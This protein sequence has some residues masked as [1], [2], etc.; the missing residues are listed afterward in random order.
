M[1][2][3][4]ATAPQDTLRLLGIGGADRGDASGLSIA[5]ASEPDDGEFIF[6]VSNEE[7]ETPGRDPNEASYAQIVYW[8]IPRITSCTG[9]SKDLE[10]CGQVGQG[11]AW[12]YLLDLSLHSQPLFGRRGA[13]EIKPYAFA[14]ATPDSQP[15]DS[16]VGIVWYDQAFRGLLNPPVART[17]TAVYVAFAQDGGK[18]GFSGPR[19]LNLENPLVPRTPDNWDATLG[20]FF[21]PCLTM[22]SIGR[23]SDNYFGEYISAAFAHREP[24]LVDVVGAW[25]DSRDGCISQAWPLTIHMHIWAGTPTPVWR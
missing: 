10:A 25:T 16:R 23:V 15:R 14:G 2:S 21:R 24:Q 4:T 20:P 18:T 5:V 1:L 12:K 11:E 19:Q 17:T 13:Y 3:V 9:G 6:L 7:I 22:H 8:R